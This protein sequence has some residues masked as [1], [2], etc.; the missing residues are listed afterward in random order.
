MNKQISK[1]LY[2]VV[3]A[4]VVIGLVLGFL[5]YFVRSFDRV[6]GVVIDGLGRQL[7]LAPF[8]ARFVFGTDSLW[9]GWGYFVLDMVVFWGG[10]GV[11]SVLVGLAS[12]LE[13]KQG[14]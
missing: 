4:E 11:A 14:A 3:I 8:V 10:V 9:A 12:K 6:T 7:E 5:A 1:L 13:I 2:G